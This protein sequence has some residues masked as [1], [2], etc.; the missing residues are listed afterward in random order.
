MTIMHWYWFQGPEITI[1]ASAVRQLPIHSVIKMVVFREKNR[2]ELSGDIVVIKTESIKEYPFRSVLQIKF[3]KKCLFYPYGKWK[4]V[5]WD[6]RSKHG[7]FN[8]TPFWV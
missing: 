4:C 6:Y 1:L 2:S 5:Y 7:S 3:E 8:S